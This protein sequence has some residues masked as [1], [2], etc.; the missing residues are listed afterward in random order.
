MANGRPI[1]Q[2]RAAKPKA[3]SVFAAL[4]SLNGIGITKVGDGYGL[5][6]NL[7]EAPPETVEL[8]TDVDGVPVVVEIVGGI[9]K[10]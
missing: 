4:A 10:Q 8:P 6:V 9:T 1:E 7:S 5:K 3:L 2:A